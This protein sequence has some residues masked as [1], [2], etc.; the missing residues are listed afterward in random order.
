[1]THF[2][3][4]VLA[5]NAVQGLKKIVES[6]SNVLLKS[7]LFEVVQ[8]YL[9][10][11]FKGFLSVSISYIYVMFTI[12]THLIKKNHHFDVFPLKCLY[13]K[14]LF[15]VDVLNKLSL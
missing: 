14:H 8:M 3:C 9:L 2:I 13:F 4:H 7:C 11:Y 12:I 1:M 15:L 10:K 6:D 5:T